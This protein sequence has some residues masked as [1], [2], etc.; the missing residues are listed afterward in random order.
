[1]PLIPA[2]DVSDD[3]L[4]ELRRRLHATRWPEPWPATGWDAGTDQGELRR[5]VRIWAEDFDW[6]AQERSIA[7]LPWHTADIDGTD[8]AYLRFDAEPGGDGVPILLT[9]GWPSTALE[10]TEVAQRL[11]TPSQ[12]GGDAA[13]AATVIVPALPGLPFSPQRPRLGVQ[14]H[15]LW[16]L[17]MTEHLGISRYLAH[18][19][20]LGA[21][22]TSRLAQ[23][24][25]DELVGIHL[26]AVAPPSDVDDA[27]ITPE[28]RAHLSRVQAWLSA[29]GAYQHQQQTR[30]LTLAPAVS[31]SPAGLLSWV[32]EKHCAWSDCD[33]DVSSRFS[34]E[35]LLTLGSLYWFTNSIGTSFRAYYEHAAGLTTAVERV[36]VPTAVAL[37]PHDLASPPQSWVERTY[38]LTRYTRMPR[39]GHFAPHEEPALLADDIAAFARELQPGRSPE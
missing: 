6:R 4:A 36:E 20:D 5:L 34:D 1:M 7:D 25:P 32:L 11:A 27:S 24:Y 15:D 37:F 31:D 9:N 3:D 33:G 39:G 2:L 30:P 19:G 14:T 12:F 28:E 26:L 21:G 22:I 10:L 17:L 18:G 8:I 35:Y 23:A 29:E 38:H 13:H 16:H